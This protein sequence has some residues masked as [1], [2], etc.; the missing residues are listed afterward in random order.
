MHDVFEKNDLQDF[1]SFSTG[2]LVGIESRYV[3]VVAEN[4]GVCPDWHAA[5]TEPTWLFVDELVVTEV[6]H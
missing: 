2:T 6:S 3:K 5:A 1:L 4:P